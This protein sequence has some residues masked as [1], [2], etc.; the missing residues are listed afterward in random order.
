[1]AIFSES[2]RDLDQEDGL[3]IPDKD[4][5]APNERLKDAE[6]LRTIYE[7]MRE[8]DEDGAYNRSIIQGEIDFIPPF[9]AKDLED[10]GQ[11]ER[12]NFN[13]GE[14]ASIKNEAV[15]GYVDIYTNPQTIVSIPLDDTVPAPEKSH[16]SRVMAEEF[17]TM[18]RSN[19]RSFPEFLRLVD[20]FV[21]HGVALTFFPDKQTLNYVS[22]G[23]DKFALPHDSSIVTADL[24]ICCCVDYMTITDLYQKIGNE[25]GDEAEG[26][27]RKAVIDLIRSNGKSHSKK[28]Y[29][30]ERIQQE[31]K[32][33]GAFV[34]SVLEKIEL[35][36]AFVKEFDGKVSF[37]IASR[38]AVTGKDL[39]D[40]FLFKKRGYYDNINEAIQIFSFS[41]GNGGML[42]SVRGLGYPIYQ[43]TNARNILYCKAMDN[44]RVESSLVVQGKTIEDLEN[45]ELIDFGGG[46][47][48]P[49]GIELPARPQAMDMNRSIIPVLEVTQQ[50][51]DRAS[52]GLSSSSMMFGK[53]D[54]KTNLEVSAQLDYINKSTSFA[55]NL[56]YPS[57]DQVMREKVRRA[58]NVRQKDKVSR[59]LVQEMRERC[60][61]RGVPEEIFKR[62][63]YRGVKATRIIGNGSRGS[64][65]LVFD[66]LRGLLSG[67]DDIGRRDYTFDY[68]SELIGHDKAIRYFGSP[69]EDRA[70]IDLSIAKLENNDL[71][72][73]EMVEPSD[74]QDHLVHLRTHLPKL[75]EGLQEVEEGILPLDE[76]ALENQLLHQHI[77]MTLE[78]T[79][80]PEE[81]QPELNS[82]IQRAQ[83]LGEVVV[84]GI[85]QANKRMR[86]EGAAMQDENGQG[87][88]PEQLKQ[89]EH[90]QKMQQ[91]AEIHNEKLRQMRE[92]GQQKMV[93]E[94]QKNM[95]DIALKHRDAEEAMA[96]ARALNQGRNI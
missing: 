58:F 38:N 76:W 16:W 88:S 13:S 9:D 29:D 36:Y 49:P 74:G 44:A 56:F 41:T 11:A 50:S 83:Q 67:M 40:G 70:P 33:N 15:S 64:R 51:L 94:A 20:T 71:L 46:I 6:S 81:L 54:R 1:M 28:W 47:G 35:I 30:W 82:Y 95:T 10:K 86:E 66:Q 23:L 7:K 59:K 85:R 60:I 65:V 68:A 45:L 19:E 34:D 17:T 61:S 78:I 57:Y 91:Q 27:N 92:L 62:I 43:I 26:W 75:E 48:I 2:E 42:M 14:A 4:G 69:D 3:L 31:I 32:S 5:L 77:T 52:G 93:L 21:T 12:F 39:N 73:G 89:L 8:D 87:P 72:S 63:D 53:G 55:L 22:G 84:N 24:E 37:Y 79:T 18:D 90:Q 96:R 80:V 25:D